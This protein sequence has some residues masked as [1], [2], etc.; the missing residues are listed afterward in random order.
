M[1]LLHDESFHVQ[2]LAAGEW[3]WVH[4]AGYRRV[5]RLELTK[6]RRI[7]LQVKDPSYLELVP[8]AKFDPDGPEV[9]A[10]RIVASLY[11]KE[12]VERELLL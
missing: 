1:G 4:S 3:W 5:P 10:L 8:V 12:W 6:D 2:A 11:G 7:G 9:V